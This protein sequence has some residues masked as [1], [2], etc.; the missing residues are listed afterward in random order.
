MKAEQKRL[1]EV[2]SDPLKV[3]KADCPI[4]T[5]KLVTPFSLQSASNPLVETKRDTAAY[6]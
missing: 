1:S 2:V 3:L 4:L 6:C 5:P